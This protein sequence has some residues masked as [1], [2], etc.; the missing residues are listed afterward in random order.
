MLSRASWAV[1]APESAL[2]SFCGGD[3]VTGHCTR[4]A[5]K[6]H[7]Q[8]TTEPGSQPIVDR[9]QS[10]LDQEQVDPDGQDADLFSQDFLVPCWSYIR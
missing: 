2:C 1:C 8:R 5:S 10:G 3:I 9:E 4:S 7:G 6:G